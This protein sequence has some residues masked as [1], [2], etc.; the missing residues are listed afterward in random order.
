M[1]LAPRQGLGEV[2]E[3]RFCGL[4]MPGGGWTRAASPTL[5]RRAAVLLRH[6][7]RTGCLIG[8]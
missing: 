5:R 2:P 6:R 7:E 1:A 8:T 4:V 3:C